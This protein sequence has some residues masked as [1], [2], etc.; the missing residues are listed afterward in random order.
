MGKIEPVVY[1]EWIEFELWLDEVQ[2]VGYMGNIEQELNF[3]GA[4]GLECYG[5]FSKTN[6]VGETANTPFEAMYLIKWCLIQ[7]FL[8]TINIV[9]ELLNHKDESAT[10][11]YGA[12]EFR[13]KLYINSSPLDK[14]MDMIDNVMN[15]KP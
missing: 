14:Y 13:V 4:D 9:P 3:I 7:N 2:V 11:T 5:D 6:Y 12:G 8:E 1:D 10:L 15:E